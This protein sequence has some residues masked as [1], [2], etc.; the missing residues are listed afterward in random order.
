MLALKF[1]KLCWCPLVFKIPLLALDCITFTFFEI[2]H[3]P[4]A[5]SSSFFCLPLFF[6]F[7]FLMFIFCILEFLFFSEVVFFCSFFFCLSSLAIC[8]SIWPSDRLFFLSFYLCLAP[9]GR[10]SD[11]LVCVA[12]AFFEAFSWVD[13][14]MSL[15]PSLASFTF[16]WVIFEAS[17]A[18]SL[19]VFVESEPFFLLPDY[20][21]S[22]FHPSFP[23][24]NL[25]LFLNYNIIII[26]LWSYLALIRRF[27]NRLSFNKTE[28][29]AL[30]RCRPLLGQL[31]LS[32]CR[33]LL[34]SL[35][36][37][38]VWKYLT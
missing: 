38:N 16:S 3:M 20:L 5:F 32:D 9:F 6:F 11:A 21:L 28:D 8:S 24:F 35:H 14:T 36:S 23:S 1:L 30:G 17:E 27:F 29:S 18:F 10:F 19:A 12:R 15:L 4:L 34:S 7:F 13:W 33:P 37:A 22:F 26:I 25:F 31:L 2:L